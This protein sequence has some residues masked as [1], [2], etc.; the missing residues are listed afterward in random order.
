[1]ISNPLN[2]HWKKERERKKKTKTKKNHNQE[3]NPNLREITGKNCF[4]T[5]PLQTEDNKLP[6]M[7]GEKKKGKNKTKKQLNYDQGLNLDL[8]L[9]VRGSFTHKKNKNKIPKKVTFRLHE[10][11]KFVGKK[12]NNN[13]RYDLSTI[14]QGFGGVG[15]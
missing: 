2:F 11:V 7:R 6:A 8:R 13:W 4:V 3:L 10:L 5:P 15:V 1:M 9:V 14:K 12:N